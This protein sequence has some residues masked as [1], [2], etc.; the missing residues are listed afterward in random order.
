MRIFLKIIS[1]ESQPFPLLLVVSRELNVQCSKK[2]KK[3]V[4]GHVL[5]RPLCYTLESNIVDV[6]L[7]LPIMF[8]FL[9]FYAYLVSSFMISY[10]GFLSLS[11]KL[12]NGLTSLAFYMT[13]FTSNMLLY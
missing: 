13:R 4:S 6:V 5:E 10:E 2:K 3:R 9:C 7:Y 8:L 12:E 11:R 1:K